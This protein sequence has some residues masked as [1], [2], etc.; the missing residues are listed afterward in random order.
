MSFGIAVNRFN[1]F[2]AQSNL[3]PGTPHPTSRL[4]SSEKFGIGMV[5][6]GI[7]LLAWAAVHYYLILHQIERHDFRARPGGV[8]S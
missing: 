8:L 4:A 5:T 7:A 2:L 6:F 1:V 3:T